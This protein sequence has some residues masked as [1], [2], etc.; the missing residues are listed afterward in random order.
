[1]AQFGKMRLDGEHSK[2]TVGGHVSL[3]FSSLD[4]LAHEKIIRETGPLPIQ[5]A[6]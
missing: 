4:H 6:C 1:L 5:Y 2:Y 3:M